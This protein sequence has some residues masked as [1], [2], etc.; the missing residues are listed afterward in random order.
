MGESRRTQR[1]ANRNCMR[2]KQ[3][4]SSFQATGVTPRP[5]FARRCCWKADGRLF[6]AKMHMLRRLCEGSEKRTTSTRTHLRMPVQM[7]ARNRS[8]RRRETRPVDQL[9]LA[10]RRTRGMRRQ[11]LDVPPGRGRIKR[12]HAL[13]KPKTSQPVHTLGTIGWKGAR[14]TP[15]RWQRLEW[16]PG[17]GEEGSPPALSAEERSRSRWSFASRAV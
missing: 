3:D 6:A 16:T 14:P 12:R 2:H 10:R 1:R 5:S 9:V 15:R 8:D 4:F 13:P 17:G 7:R 11:H